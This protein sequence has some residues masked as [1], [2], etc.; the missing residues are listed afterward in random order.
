MAVFH[1]LWKVG[2]LMRVKNWA[3]FQHFRDRRPPWIK[4]Y[5]DLLD[6]MEWH[7]LDPEAA[8]A[9]VMIWLLASE[10]EGNVPDIKT[11]AFRLRASET[12]I[13]LIISKLSHWLEHDDITVISE[14]Y[15]VDSP[16][17]ERETERER[18]LMSDFESFW[19]AFPG[20]RKGNKDKAAAAFKSAIKRSPPSEII[21]ALPAYSA[22]DEVKR[23]FAKGA[24]AW[25]N[26][27]RWKV[28]YSA[29]PNGKGAHV[30]QPGDL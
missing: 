13:N 20:T 17:T 8:K 22:S 25:L 11:L 6:D 1:A 30:W 2:R 27:D 29:K 28:N 12:K 16:E 26:D 21:G 4:L 5:R 15:Q 10:D 14:G 9:L 18:E 7:T 3:Q 23:G 19:K 24:A